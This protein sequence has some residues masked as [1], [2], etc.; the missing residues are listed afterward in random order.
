MA[1]LKVMKDSKD[2]SS[3]IDY[4]E[5]LTQTT[6]VDKCV[7]K[8]GYM[9]DINDFRNQAELVQDQF[10]KKTGRQAKHYTLNFAEDELNQTP[11]DYQRCLEMGWLWA[12]ENFPKNQVGIYVHGNTD[13]V[14]CHILVHTLDIETGN[15]LQ[16]SK[17]DLQKFKES[18][19]SICNE[20]GINLLL[21]K[22]QS[23]EFEY[24]NIVSAHNKEKSWTETL[25]EKIDEV[26]LTATSYDDFKNKLDEKGITLE[27]KSFTNYE[28]NET[29]NYILITDVSA[30]N[31]SGK[32]RKVKNT[33]LG[34][35]FE[36]GQLN[37]QFNKNNAIIS[38][39]KQTVTRNKVYFSKKVTPVSI[40]LS[41]NETEKEEY[42]NDKQTMINE[43]TKEKLRESKSQE[44]SE[45][46]KKEEKEQKEFVSREKEIQQSDDDFYDSMIMFFNKTNQKNP[47][48]SLFVQNENTLYMGGYTRTK[49]KINYKESEVSFSKKNGKEYEVYKS[50]SVK[51]KDDFSKVTQEINTNARKHELYAIQMG[52]NV[53]S[54]KNRE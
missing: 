34:K 12:K 9:C 44:E 39:E 1:L 50:F 35:R 30:E 32:E 43:H 19:N 2:I 10:G 36:E 22:N 4:C 24:K 17:N 26:R 16:V 46:I 31:E 41:G 25:K 29:K 23:K 7:L 13:N 45:R 48:S 28:T 38:S 33:T 49:F 52:Q 53:Q 5:G 15:K 14:H 54:Q 42:I 3:S 8:T 40:H 37:K 21:E 27:R 11:E 51:S 6:E 20:Y 18:A 47:R